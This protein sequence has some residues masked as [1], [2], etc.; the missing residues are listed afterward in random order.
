MRG[1]ML[2]ALQVTP[3][4]LCVACTCASGSA[5]PSLTEDNFQYAG[6]IR[7]PLRNGVLYQ[8]RLE[9][10]VLEKCAAGCR[11]LRVFHNE[12]EIPYVI[13][14]NRNDGRTP[15]IY[16]LE[17]TELD[18]Q[19]SVTTLIMKMPQ[20]Y[21]PIRRMTLDVPDRDFRK[22]VTL[23]GSN[24]LKTW[25][26]VVNDRIYDFTSQVDLRKTYI[27]FPAS[28]FRYYRL[29]MRDEARLTAKKDM[30]TLKYQGLDFSVSGVE[31]RK[32]RIGKV[33]GQTFFESEHSA[34]YD[35]TNMTAYRIEQDKDRDTVIAFETGIPFTRISFDVS[36]PYFY[37]KASIY[38][39]DTGKENSFKLLQSSSIYRL[40]F[41]DIT[42]SKNILDCSSAGSRFYR[43]V[44]ENRSNPELEI[45]GIRLGWVQKHLFFVGLDDADSYKAGLGNSAVGVPDYDLSKS[46][47]QANWQ[48]VSSEKT[49]I[50]GIMQNPNFKPGFPQDARQKTE[51]TVLIVVVC[52]LVA[53]ISYWLYRLLSKAGRKPD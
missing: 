3:L 13:I 42:E 10:P 50:T 22:N 12:K 18:E 33:M 11:D 31:A 37:R 40:L 47:N 5:L 39:S 35:E 36:N 49:E 7:G 26:V 41:S 44:I 34:V 17:I 32:L 14:E 48:K 52:L 29:V 8:V 2:R 19:G 27:S 43:I 25:D 9:T 4:V 20:K 21:E 28:S 51:K 1:G 24:D 53:G 38:S 23:E 6:T 15:S 45:K 30:L 46:I 16:P